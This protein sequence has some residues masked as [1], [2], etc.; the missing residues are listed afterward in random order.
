MERGKTKFI[1]KL[2]NG[3]LFT[4]YSKPVDD[5]LS[6]SFCDKFNLF[7][8]FPKEKFEPEIEEVFI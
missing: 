8:S 7:R 6:I 1:I 4:S 3:L 2:N 5:G